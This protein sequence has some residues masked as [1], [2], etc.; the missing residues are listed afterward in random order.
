MRPSVKIYR[1]L[2]AKWALKSLRERRLRVSRIKELN[3]PFEW[4]IGSVADLPGHANAGRESF[5]AF[6]ERINEQL[7]VISHSA[8]SADPVIWSHYAD[9]HKGI[10]LEFDH[11]L[12]EELHPVS[13]SHSLPIFDVTRFLKTNSDQYTLSILKTALG[14]KS[15][16]WAY[17]KEYR[18]H[19]GLETDCEKE[20]GNYFKRIPENYLK[21]VILGVRCAASR[22]EVIE[23]LGAGGFSDVE[24][25]RARFSETTY[26]V[27]CD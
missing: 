27:L 5:D 23:A 26:E 1:Y 6:V 19:F 21:R 9:S 8:A 4:R 3:D 11:F 7:G 16:S 17:E 20:E 24:V 2:E 10:A 14:R 18:V 15:L 22:S 13:Y 25:V 12:V